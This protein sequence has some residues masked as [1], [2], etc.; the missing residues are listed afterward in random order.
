LCGP[1]NPDVNSPDW[2]TNYVIYARLSIF[3]PCL[4]CHWQVIETC[5]F[6]KGNLLTGA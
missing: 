3:R 6:I 1:F 4:R 2:Q 5:R